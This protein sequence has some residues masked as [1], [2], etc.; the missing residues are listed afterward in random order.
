MSKGER[1]IDEDILIRFVVGETSSDESAMV[2]E[3]VT[4]SN[5]NR[6]QLEQIRKTWTLTSDPV[7]AEPAEV[8]VDLA[9]N[10]VKSRMVDFKEIEKKIAPKQRSIGYYFVRVAAVLVIGIMVYGIIQYQFSGQNSIQIASKD[11][12][13]TDNPLPDGTMI[14]LN[15][16]TTIEYQKEFSGKERRVKLEGEAFFDVEP[17]KEKPFVI[18]A[19]D[20]IITVLGTSFNVKAMKNDEAVEVL[21]EEGLV[22]LSNPDRSQSTKLKVGEKGIFLKST[23]EVKKETE[24]DVE[25][26]YWLNKTLLFRDTELSVVFETLE[27]LY[28]VNIEVDNSSINTCLLTA[29]FSNETIE[30]ILEHIS[31][32][33]ELEIT[34][35]NQTILL[36]GNGCP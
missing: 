3:W 32:I 21:V 36:K 15:Q 29:K 19:Q 9:W 26:L 30:H 12:T 18:Q 22:E 10:K 31:I 20:A 7:K 25:S 1:H 6:S 24:I 16:N 5:D 23:N 28:D 35:Q 17:D 2:E 14:A 8:N 33:F 4:L 34:N 11:S 13:I 27:R